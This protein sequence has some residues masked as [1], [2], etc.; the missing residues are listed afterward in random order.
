MN[1]QPDLEDGHDARKAQVS[2]VA[3]TMGRLRLLMGRRFMSRIAL[4]RLGDGHGLELS[5]HDTIKIVARLEPYQEVTVGAVAEQMRI[6]PSR[7]SRVI[8]DLVRNGML[9]REA[10]QEDARRTVVK[11][12]DQAKNLMAHFEAVRH[13][14]LG[15][16]L[17]GWS[18]EELSL[19]ASQFDRFILDLENR[20]ADMSREEEA[21]R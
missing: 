19:F 21:P 17:E 6:D 10:S 4:Q 16:T 7:A 9:K 8:A 2:Q 5:H 14:A 1:F 20:F 11:M 15:Q 3:E 12:T 18:D 13:E